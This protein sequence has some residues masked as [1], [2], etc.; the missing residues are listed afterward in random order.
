[1]ADD[2]SSLTIDNSI[3]RN[4]KTETL[5]SQQ[6][7]GGGMAVEPYASLTVRSTLITRCNASSS[8]DGQAS[9][10]AIFVNDHGRLTV[11]STTISECSTS[12]TTSRKHVWGG[13]IRI[14]PDSHATFTRSTIASCFVIA[15]GQ[16]VTSGTAAAA[17][18]GAFFVNDRAILVFDRSH[19]SDCAAINRGAGNAVG[20][21]MKLDPD[22]V[23]T[24]V[25]SSIRNV[26]SIAYGAGSM[27]TTKYAGGYGGTLYLSSRVKLTLNGSE[28]ADCSNVV[29]G[30]GLAEGGA[31]CAYSP[32]ASV[33]LIDSTITR[34]SVTAHG[35]RDASGGAF[36]FR[37]R[38]SISLD[39]STIRE[40][41][42][43]AK[44]V[45]GAYG[46]AATMEPDSSMVL[47]RSTVTDSFAVA[48]QDGQ[49]VGGAFMLKERASLTLDASTINACSATTM[50]VETA[51]GG[52]IGIYPDASA[53]VRSTV[54]TACSVTA[55]GSGFA[56]GG[57]FSVYDRAI[58]TLD[59]S[60]VSDSLCT[61]L[62][63]GRAEG[64]V[65]RVSRSA[66][67][68]LKG[69]SL[70]NGS[71][72]ARGNE[73]ASGGAMLIRPEAKVTLEES[74][75][76][77]CRAVAHL[78]S[79]EGGG[80]V[81]KGGVLL[82]RK[83]SALRGNAASSR[84]ATMVQQGDVVY[85]LPA[86]LGTWI[87]AR[88][89]QV[90]RR[91]CPEDPAS[92]LPVDPNCP[93]TA[94]ACSQDVNQT[95]LVNGTT[96]QPILSF[97]PC[98][99][100]SMPELL[101]QLVDMLPHT[102][103]EVDYP[104]ACSAGLLRS[105]DPKHQTTSLCGG[106]C[107][108]SYACPAG[109]NP[110]TCPM[111]GYCPR[112][113]SVPLPCPSG[114]YGSTTGL[115]AISDCTPCPKGFWCSAGKAIACPLHTYN[116]VTG[117]DDQGDCISCPPHAV[118]EFTSAHSI[119]QCICE[120]N[121]YD[122]EEPDQ[123]HCKRCPLGALCERQGR[124]LSHLRLRHGFYRASNRS[125]DVRRCPDAVPNCSTTKCD[126]LLSGCLGEPTQP[127]VD[128]LRGHYCSKQSLRIASFCTCSH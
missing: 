90:Y 98:T 36:F 57:A 6:T 94:N 102:I 116:N 51:Q 43:V 39:A 101:G 110:I 46:G 26:Y 28:I 121:Y 35:G 99:W 117:A 49:A 5:G 66:T 71:A 44:G 118:T 72:I 97:Q 48:R 91:F 126:G 41:S 2:Y 83:G 18:G 119:S 38:V 34:C 11:D 111:G 100:T 64:G 8:G 105:A 10:G 96:C 55:Q 40:C 15:Q 78:N 112:G 113:S 124:T 65:M 60:T 19:I 16:Q 67:V 50:G 17:S 114:L 77:S 122:A 107:P 53:T 63:N 108:A 21:A 32:D 29:V 76:T 22:S 30:N 7:M 27:S 54:V 68:T 80:V 125:V 14:D 123:V 73:R 45:G 92:G 74:V 37:V 89:C 59:D 31:I 23:V 85:V 127:C 4:C 70:I 24:F 75:I 87:A 88:E 86:P 109:Q 103:M 3:I 58:L 81:N 128:G 93:L 1:M 82:L 42:A 106:L 20:G 33:K 84:G 62:G 13:A 61:T 79:G 104:Y 25:R 120:E 95:A 52:A 9:A 12:T 115:S 69:S 56:Y 47:T